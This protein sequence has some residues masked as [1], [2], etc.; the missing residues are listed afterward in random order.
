MNSE[1]ISAFKVA[2][3]PV[4]VARSRPQTTHLTVVLALEKTVC[5]LSQSGH[6]TFKKL[7]EFYYPLLVGSVIMGMVCA[8]ITYFIT[9]YI[10]GK[11][12]EKRERR[13]KDTQI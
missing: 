11:I 4:G 2:F 10:S 13:D 3:P 5:S 8:V 1:T 9:L 12:K 7:G 6:F